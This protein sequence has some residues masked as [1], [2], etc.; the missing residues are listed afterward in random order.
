MTRRARSASQYGTQ[1]VAIPINTFEDVYLKL[2]R[3]LG[4]G[5]MAVIGGQA[6][7]VWCHEQRRGSH[8]IDI[9]VRKELTSDD[10]AR[11]EAEGFFSR[12]DK[13]LRFVG[14]SYTD[15]YF[16]NVDIDL[17]SQGRPINGISQE[18]LFNNLEERPIGG[19]RGSMAMVP[20]KA[21]LAVMKMDSKRE[22]DI[23]DVWNILHNFY[24]G[25]S[26]EF[27][28]TERAL[29]MDLF[30]SSDRVA[31]F[32]SMMDGILYDGLTRVRRR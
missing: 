1:K 22:Q 7:N 24:N 14:F 31:A 11:L 15:H 21:L 8:D 12:Y 17:M 20:S 25:S 4:K 23:K 18:M 9:V 30:G 13:K 5:E 29:L 6:V 19:A 2:E 3:I 16:G 27:V 10:Y 32:Q 26:R 28:S